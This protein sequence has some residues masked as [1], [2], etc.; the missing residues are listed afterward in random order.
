MRACGT[1][2]MCMR[3]VG[4]CGWCVCSLMM[5]YSLMFIRRVFII[6]SFV[7]ASVRLASLRLSIPSIGF[8]VLIDVLTDLSR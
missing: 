5:D 4:V 2:S 8:S 6:I 3:V 7:S 1:C